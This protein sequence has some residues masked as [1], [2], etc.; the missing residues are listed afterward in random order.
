MIIDTVDLFLTNGWRLSRV[1]GHL[2]Q[3]ARK[4]ILKVQGYQTKDLKYEPRKITVTL[5][6]KF[7]TEAL[8][9]AGMVTIYDIMEN[10]SLHTVEITEH[11]MTAFSAVAREG[12]KVT[13]NKQVATV[14]IIFTEATL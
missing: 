3:P 4:K 2:D 8:M 5:V 13:I 7:A 6:G 1:D 9:Y 11:N 14:T 10:A 12:V